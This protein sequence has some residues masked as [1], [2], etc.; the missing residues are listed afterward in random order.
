MWLSKELVKVV[1]HFLRRASACLL[2][3]F[4]LVCSLCQWFHSRSAMQVVTIGFLLRWLWC[5]QC[6]ETILNF[7]C[8]LSLLVLSSVSCF[9]SY[10]IFFYC[11]FCES[12]P[13]SDNSMIRV[14]G[15]KRN[16]LFFYADL[17]FISVLVETWYECPR[18]TYT[19]DDCTLDAC[20]L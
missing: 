2:L 12:Y 1:L 11:C 19:F 17:S 9:Q 4:Q 5:L 15:G 7:H 8:V 13:S 16:R 10:L 18:C 6:V 20:T 14:H 3:P